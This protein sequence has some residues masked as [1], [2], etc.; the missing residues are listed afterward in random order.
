[1]PYTDIIEDLQ[2]EQAVLL[3]GPEAMRLG[4]QSLMQHLYAHLWVRAG[5]EVVYYYERDGLFLFANE[6][7][8]LRVQKQ[9]K[10]QLRALSPDEEWLQ[11]LVALP[12]PL[13][14]SLTPDTFLRD[15]FAKYGVEA[16]FGYFK[17]GETA[18]EL[19]KGEKGKPLVYN[20]LG[21][22]EEEESLVLDYEDMFKLMKGALGGL[23]DGLPRKLQAQLARATTYIFVGFEF[24]KWHTQMLIRIL[25]E[26]KGIN[27]YAFVGDQTTQGTRDFLMKEFK[28]SFAEGEKEG[29][30]LLDCLY[31]HC[32]KANIL[33]PIASAYSDKQL[34]IMRLIYSA[35]ILAALEELLKEK[36]FETEVGVFSAR[37]HSLEEGKARMD[38]RDYSVEWNKV[39][40]GLLEIVKQV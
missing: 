11:R 22:A 2:D 30:T 16:H 8:K 12:F 31:R 33:R 26:R 20:L 13:R 28:I 36:E 37:F 5:E 9:V 17:A 39:V 24:E 3:I 27:K 35:K 23:G 18:V 38:S 10:R 14:L 29:E 4:E 25:S 1:M 21:M 32:E 6:E 15:A 34:K 19:P 7:A 40:Y